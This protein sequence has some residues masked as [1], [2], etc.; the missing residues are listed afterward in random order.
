MDVRLPAN[1]LF[2][3]R[4]VPERARI[5]RVGRKIPALKRRPDGL[6][7]YQ[8]GR[9]RVPSLTGPVRHRQD[10]AAL[11][12]YRRAR[13]TWLERDMGDYG[14]FRWVAAARDDLA[15]DVAHRRYP[16]MHSRP[17]DRDP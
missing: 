8:K 7:R 17:E 3:R 4:R 1:Q 14:G 5:G 6:D 12:D 16:P 13:L 15:H 11:V 10:A 9:V 2:E